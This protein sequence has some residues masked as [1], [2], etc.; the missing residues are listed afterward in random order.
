MRKCPNGNWH[1]IWDS[2]CRCIESNPFF[3]ENGKWK[4]ASQLIREEGRASML[5]WTGYA[6]LDT[7]ITF[8]SILI[9]LAFAFLLFE[10]LVLAGN[11]MISR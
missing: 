4:L 2:E 9:G 1:W 11:R 6:I 5:S 7:V 3:F 8:A 10:S